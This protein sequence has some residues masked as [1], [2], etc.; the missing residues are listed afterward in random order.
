L[1]KH[2]RTAALL[3]LAVLAARASAETKFAVDPEA[4]NNTFTAVFDAA[5][6]ERITAVS[7]A[8]GCSM[9]VDETTL[10]GKAS[11][12]V[13]L[14]SIRVDNDETKSDHFRQ[15]ATNKQ[16]EPRKCV[17]QLDVPGI[18]LRGFVEAMKPVAFETEGTFTLCG[19]KRDDQGAEKI[20]GTILYLPAKEY[21][22]AETPRTSPRPHE[23]PRTIRIRARIEGFDRERYRIG[24]RWTAGWFARVQQ[25]APVV[26]TEG[27]IEVNLFA[28]EAD[29][30]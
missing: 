14:T 20:Q 18:K 7:S 19:R 2:P 28:M 15:W 10:E 17:F 27:T 21:D 1:S 11:C 16:V 3:L 4:G 23:V 9:A 29:G 6:G 22:A 5:V 26:A 13:P 8:V 12:S 25:L 30:K 24:P